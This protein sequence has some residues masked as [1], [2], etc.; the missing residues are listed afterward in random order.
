MNGEVEKVNIKLAQ[1]C[2]FCAAES[3]LRHHEQPWNWV[4]RRGDCPWRWRLPA[5]GSS[6]RRELGR[7]LSFGEN[8][9]FQLNSAHRLFLRPSSNRASLSHLPP[10]CLRSHRCSC[11]KWSIACTS[12]H[13]PGRAGWGSGEWGRDFWNLFRFELKKWQWLCVPWASG[14][15]LQI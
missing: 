4:W 1:L 9:I 2:C 10:P 8:G 3:I 13:V 15:Q 5:P 12:L 7:E 14:C 6:V 11:P